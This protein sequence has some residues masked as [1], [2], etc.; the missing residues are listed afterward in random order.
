MG[1]SADRGCWRDGLWIL[2]DWLRGARKDAIRVM[3]RAPSAVADM[4]ETSATARPKRTEETG[5]GLVL[6]GIFF[7]ISQTDGHLDATSGDLA[8]CG[9]D[10]ERSIRSNS[11][12][13]GVMGVAAREEFCDA[14]VEGVEA[15]CS[16]T[17]FVSV[18]SPS[19]GSTSSS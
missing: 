15:L 9:G 8:K 19:I 14:A 5:E 18:V 1:A 11:F 16:T 2:T 13:C 17:P 7:A 4:S 12:A 10:A 6:I 3:I